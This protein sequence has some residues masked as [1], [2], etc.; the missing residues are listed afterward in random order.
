[1]VAWFIFPFCYHSAKEFK[2]ANFWSNASGR[3]VLHVHAMSITLFGAIVFLEIDSARM[4]YAA[5][6]G[7]EGVHVWDT[8]TGELH[9]TLQGPHK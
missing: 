3:R 4:V 6:G 5:A 7:N 8:M 9:S 2:P 1:M